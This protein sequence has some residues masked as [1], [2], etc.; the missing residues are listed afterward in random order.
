MKNELPL[1]LKKIIP[2]S[3]WNYFQEKK[4]IKLSKEINSL[5]NLNKLSNQFVMKLLNNNDI[6]EISS[7][8]IEDIN[9]DF[10]ILGADSIFFEKLMSQYPVLYPEYKQLIKKLLEKDKLISILR[11]YGTVTI[12]KNLI[13]LVNYDLL[14]SEK[15]IEIIN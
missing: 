5:M 7:L 9:N 8:I 13:I 14:S 1:I 15:F 12:I 3:S 11:R 2:N 10:L 6:A 4:S